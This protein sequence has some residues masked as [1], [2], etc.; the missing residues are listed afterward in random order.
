MNLQNKSGDQN[1]SPM[2]METTI[3]NVF[4]SILWSMTD[5]NFITISML[6]ELLISIHD[7]LLADQGY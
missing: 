3:Y 7:E 2:F 5:L 4:N 6:L 1:N